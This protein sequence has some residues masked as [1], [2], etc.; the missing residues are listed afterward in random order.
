[1]S[2][3]NFADVSAR[4][5][6]PS[7]HA[8][9]E[10]LA[11]AASVAVP[12]VLAAAHLANVADAAHDEGVVRAVGFGWTGAWRALDPLVAA[13][14]EVLPIGTRSMRAGLV[15]VLFVAA[16]AALVHLV[17]RRL[18]SA[19]AV[20]ERLGAFVASIATWTVVGGAAWQLEGASAGGSVFGATLVL[21][22]TALV[23]AGAR[24]DLRR[25]PLAAA[26][27]GLAVSYEPLA[28]VSAV[29][30]LVA[31]VVWARW[32]QGASSL[33]RRRVFESSGAFVVAFTPAAFGAVR[34]RAA[35]GLELGGD[36][37][38]T[39]AGERG[40]SVRS[41]V[42]DFVRAEMSAAIVLLAV[43][44][45]VLAMLVA[46]ARPLAVAT[47]LV[48]SCG[49]VAVRLGAPAGPTR[50]AAP[51]LAG[52]AATTML[53]AVALQALVRAVAEARIPFARAS[54][55]MIAILELMLPFRATDDAT[56][57]SLDRARGVAAMWD[58][59]AWGALPD[60]ALVLV[61][62]ARVMTR[63][64]ASRAA[65]T[66]RGDLAVVPTFD[67]DGPAAHAELV[68]EP[69]LTPI[70][71]DMALSA[72]PDEF[73]LS[74]LAGARPLIVVFDAKWEES[75]ARHLVPV[76]LA[77]RFEPEPRGASDRRR[78][79]DAFVP[80]RDELARATVLDRDPELVDVT[81]R[82]L[83]SRALALAA[84]GE[85][86]MMTRG[87]DDLHM[88]APK[89]AVADLIARRAVRTRGAVDVS[90]IAF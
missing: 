3:G 20:T 16:G 50:F 18:L 64:L 85:K 83:R 5:R 7:P 44:G 42:G 82:L 6:E 71:R 31:L 13:A 62:D 63:V 17:T 39:W 84:S 87:I 76:G 14:L 68:R 9:L 27:A 25:L 11:L 69:N 45:L 36:P 37:F 57:R 10:A 54:A 48:A 32:T 65:G 35:R 88:F 73:S 59:V 34:W 86:E 41:T 77:T 38:A 56:T 23:A 70:W 19:C 66:L 51:V 22:P 90:D 2:R 74:A 72:H 61:S 28:G 78:A 46:R 80:E 21:A 15:S 58:E 12:A 53:A 40:A 49:L 89:D 75:L 52:M 67:L 1:V 81:A 8:R 30:P 29:A 55:A 79:L 47:A 43:V 26:V 60:G 33:P 24:L 4:S